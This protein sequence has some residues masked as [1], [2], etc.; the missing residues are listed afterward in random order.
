M[1]KLN[2]MQKLIITFSVLLASCLSCAAT[3]IEKFLS[4]DYIE[5]GHGYIKWTRI[6]PAYEGGLIV[7]HG[8]V[9]YIRVEMKHGRNIKFRDFFHAEEAKISDPDGKLFIELQKSS[10]SLDNETRCFFPSMLE[11][12]VPHYRQRIY[13]KDVLILSNGITRTLGAI[14][15]CK[16]SEYRDFWEDQGIGN[17]RDLPKEFDPYYSCYESVM[18][19]L[20]TEKETKEITKPKKLMLKLSH[21][22][23]LI[24]PYYPFEAEAMV[25]MASMVID[26]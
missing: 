5:N 8:Y 2:M 25:N 12:G 22:A 3:P 21:M 15:D 7:T 19:I 6:E 17:S 14:V 26:P 13:I 9:D 24:S 4:F 10:L 18:N 20:K 16:S 23:A 1:R 11:V